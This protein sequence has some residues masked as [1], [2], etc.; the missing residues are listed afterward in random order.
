MKANLEELRDQMIDDS[1]DG[2][3]ESDG[4]TQCMM[5]EIAENSMRQ[6]NIQEPNTNWIEQE[7]DEP[8]YEMIHVIFL[9]FIIWLFYVL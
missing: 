3:S 7:H 1:Y 6:D 8:V 5:E 9:A 4:S 2:F